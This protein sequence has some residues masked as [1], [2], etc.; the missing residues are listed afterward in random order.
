MSAGGRRLPGRRF[1]SRVLATVI[2]L[3]AA[4]LLSS[5]LLPRASARLPERHSAIATAP[6]PRAK[7]YPKV[8][9]QSARL[10]V[11]PLTVLG[12]RAVEVQGGSWGIR[13]DGCKP[14]VGLSAF[15]LG[16]SAYPGVYLGR[17]QIHAPA[18]RFTRTWKT[19]HVREGSRWA[20]E[21]VQRCHGAILF[22]YA[23]VTLKGSS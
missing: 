6:P 7:P 8:G 1:H 10:S 19:P 12:G 23:I 5:L 18:R 9:P 16:V 14:S 17:F 2:L 13:S 15:A 21:G 4:A 11:R 20:I 3:S 22:R